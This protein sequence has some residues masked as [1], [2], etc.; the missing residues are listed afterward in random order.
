[1]RNISLNQ[2]FVIIVL[3]ILLFSDLSKTIKNIHDLFR[4]SKFYKSL[5]KK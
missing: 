3:G 2:L 4:N 1:M 5:K